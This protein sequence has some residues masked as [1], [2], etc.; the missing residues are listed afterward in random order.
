MNYH[1]LSEFRVGHTVFLD[2]L[3]TR[4]V[5]TL[6]R[7][8]LVTLKR[9]AQDGMRVRASA[10]AASFRRRP[11]LEACQSE[12]RE[13]V[14]SLRAEVAS[15]PSA[16]NRRREAA[17]RRAARERSE[18]IAK[19]LEE[20]PRAEAKKKPAEKAKARVSTTEPEARVMKM[21]D[22]GFR[23]AHNVQFA[24]TTEGQVITG[25]D[26]VN[27]GSDQGQM[28]PMVRQHKERYGETPGEMLVDGGFAKQEDIERVEAPE[29][30]TTV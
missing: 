12:A 23:P 10:G 26:V 22:G 13:Q 16:G 9:V 20:M 2:K 3:L 25:V 6:M 14:E 24:A 4:S 5:A 27:T 8:G 21:G 29:N 1:T 30:G 11:T 19:A 18:R 7:E 28:G 15:D 17:R